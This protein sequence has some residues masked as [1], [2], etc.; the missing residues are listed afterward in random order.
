[1]TRYSAPVYCIYTVS[2]E[3]TVNGTV[4][5]SKL[6]TGGFPEID[7]VSVAASVIDDCLNFMLLLICSK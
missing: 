3:V 2:F 4:V 5:F 6:K 1:M 7:A